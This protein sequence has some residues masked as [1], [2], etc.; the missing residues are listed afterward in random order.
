M[1]NNSKKGNKTIKYPNPLEALKDIGSSTAKSFQKD[2]L[3]KM[4]DDF[5][6]QLFGVQKKEKISGEISAGESLEMSQVF[7]GQQKE[8]EAERKQIAVERS[9]LEQ[10]K[11]LVSEKSNELKMRLQVLMNEL[12]AV[13]KQTEGLA[14]EVQ[15]AAMQAPS[16]P[17]IYHLIFFEKLLDFLKSFRKKIAEARIWLHAVNKRAAKK[18]GNVWGSNY[19]KSGGKYLLSGEHYLQRSAG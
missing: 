18:G 4:P 8:V 10:E 1:N 15:I 14:E 9:L 2:F 11:K 13:S 12:L 5:M 7:S 19:K 3:G 17:G 6:E 16:E